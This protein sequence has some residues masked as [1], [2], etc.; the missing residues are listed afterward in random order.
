MIPLQS[1]QESRDHDR[2]AISRLGVAGSL[3]M[4]NAGRGAAECIAVDFPNDLADVLV[5][6]GAG[7]NG[8]D[9]WVVARHLA[10]TGIRVRCFFVG[11]RPRVAGDA[12]PNLRSLEMLGLAPARVDAGGLATFAAACRD[13]SL[14][15]EGLFGTGLDRPISGHVAQVVDALNGAGTPVVSLD[16]PSGVDADTG[17][18]LGTAVRARTTVAFGAAKRG[19]LQ[20]PGRGLSGVLHRVGLGVPPPCRAGA[21]IVERRDVAEQVARR[22]A[23]AHKGTAGHLLV[24]AGS[25]GRTG[26]CLLAGRSA[27]RAGA[28]L[29]T[30]CP[31]QEA[32]ASLDAKVVELMTQALPVGPEALRAALP[33]LCAGKAA[34][35]VGPGLGTDDSGRALCREAALAL[36]LP[37][38][39]DADALTAFAGEPELL[40]SAAGPRVLTPHP[41]EAAVLLGSDSATIQADRYA[42]ATELATRS[43]QVTLLKGAGTVVA[44]PAGA[45]WV[46]DRGTPALGVAGTGD[47]LSGCVGALLAQL[48]PAEAAYCGAYLHALAGERAAAAL[49]GCADRG[50]LASEVADALPG[51]L[52]VCRGD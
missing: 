26:A 29:V 28:G 32:A 37:A 51:A 23:D 16:L 42:A 41:G 44:A 2:H 11:D 35:V 47:V 8:G 45:L 39:L 36:S 33:G 25:P 9:A 4:E 19:H 6:G 7:Q 30:L 50:L 24:L 15:V 49:H 31:R 21:W 48:A 13:A 5:V 27:L 10:S 20:H 52:A 38:V 18:V 34:A 43:G 14:L 3:L 12:L 1:R 40:R 46:I 22:T 17:A